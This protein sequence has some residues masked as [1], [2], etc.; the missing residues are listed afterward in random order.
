VIGELVLVGL[1]GTAATLATGAYAPNSRLFGPVIGRGPQTSPTLYLT[2][3]DGP[4]SSATPRILETL[5]RFAVP[6]TF[7]LVGAQVR[8]SPDLARAVH[9]AGHEIGNHTETHRK[10]HLASPRTSADELGRAHQTIL[11]VVGV[12]PRLFRAPHG[13]KNPFVARA[14]RD[15]GYRLVGWTFGVWDSDCPGA[16]TIRRRVAARLRPGAIVLLHDGD[17]YDPHGDRS[18]TAE[19]LSGIITDARERGYQFRPL[20]ELLA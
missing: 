3:D 1:A 9:A 14:A 4:S 16:A 2:F 18:Q 8:R 12:R 11:D 19:A 6:A 5:A 7:F 13:Y 10:L 20:S 15:L 17:G